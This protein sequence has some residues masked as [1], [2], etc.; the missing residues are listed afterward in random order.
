MYAFYFF[1]EEIDCQRG[2]RIARNTKQQTPAIT[3]QH[4]NDDSECTSGNRGAAIDC[5]HPRDCGIAKVFFC[6]AQSNR[7]HDTPKNKSEDDQLQAVDRCSGIH[8][9]VTSHI[10]STIGN[11]MTVKH[12]L[13]CRNALTKDFALSVSFYL[14]GKNCLSRSIFL[15]SHFAAR[16]PKVTIVLFVFPS[17]TNV[18]WTRSP[19]LWRRSTLMNG[20]F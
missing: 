8:R 4:R 6:N 7:K 10:I 9:S 14:S 20:R 18:I 13:I 15:Q 16:L 1:R 2:G 3:Q 12:T 17:R 5:L 11:S 19:G